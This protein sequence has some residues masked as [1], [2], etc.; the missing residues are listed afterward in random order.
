MRSGGGGNGFDPN[1]PRASFEVLLGGTKSDLE[2]LK[3]SL[4]PIGGLLAILAV[5]WLAMSS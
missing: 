2:Q 3:G 4:K 1:D 5:V